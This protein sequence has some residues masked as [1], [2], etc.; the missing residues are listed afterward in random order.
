LYLDVLII[1]ASLQ[2]SPKPPFLAQNWHKPFYNPPPTSRADT[3]PQKVSKLVAKELH[4][5]HPF[6][7]VFC[8]P[9]HISVSMFLGVFVL[10]LSV[11]SLRSW[12]L[13]G[14]T[15]LAFAF[16]A[17]HSLISAATAQTFATRRTHASQPLQLRQ[18]S[19]ISRASRQPRMSIRWHYGSVP[20][21]I[22]ADKLQIMQ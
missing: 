2:S 9:V 12:R 6:S 1:F 5:G 7:L 15:A 21:V 16:S 8:Y 13:G 18:F 17:D 22:S 20:P 3:L 19:G 11:F 10:N 14:S 4:F